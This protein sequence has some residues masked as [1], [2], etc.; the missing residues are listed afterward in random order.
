[1]F[2]L[3]GTIAASAAVGATARGSVSQAGFDGILVR[4]EKYTDISSVDIKAVLYHEKGQ[5]VLCNAPLLFLAER[6]DFLGGQS[7]G[8]AYEQALETTAEAE[9]LGQ[10]SVFIPLGH[11][12][13]SG[14]DELEVTASVTTAIDAA[15]GLRISA[16]DYGP[17]EESTVAIVEKPTGV[18][19]FSFP[20]E[21]YAYR[22]PTDTNEDAV[23][24]IAAGA[25][26]I[27][28]KTG[29]RAYSFDVLDAWAHTC[30]TG[31]IEGKGPRRTA[32]IHTDSRNRNPS[33]EFSAT[34][35]GSDKANW[36]LFGVERVLI[37]G[38]A[39]AKAAELGTF[40]QAA[41]MRAAV[42]A[43]EKVR[44]LRIKGLV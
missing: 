20:I 29:A 4:C 1:M 23:A 15:G 21:A 40:R 10:I 12:E 18:A 19:N 30:A 8:A 13:L 6:S 38:R 17:G 42:S 16:V 11:T 26:V 31:N 2:A 22:T 25:C 24:E 27:T 37:P 39:E 34:V 5:E 36:T 44:A 28:T 14:D 41:L 35:T 3:L 32:N 7:F 33:G 43:P 9:A